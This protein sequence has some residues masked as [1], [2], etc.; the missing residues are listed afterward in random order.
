MYT[1]TGVSFKEEVL[2]SLLGPSSSTKRQ[3]QALHV[4]L[5]ALGAAIPAAVI[6]GDANGLG[7]LLRNLRLPAR[8]IGRYR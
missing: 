5:K 6:D 4:G 8:E 2:C 7:E 1:Y 3:L